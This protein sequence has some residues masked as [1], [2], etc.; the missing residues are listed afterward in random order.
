MPRSVAAFERVGFIVP[1]APTRF[2]TGETINSNSIFDW[3][4]AADAL[5][6]SRAGT[7]R[8]VIGMLYYKLRY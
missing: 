8:I 6:T 3:L 1:P 2:T 7:A 5:V 4:S